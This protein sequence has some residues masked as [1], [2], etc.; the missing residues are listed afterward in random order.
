MKIGILGSG[1]VG[2]TLGSKLLEQGHEVRLGARNPGK[3][4]EWLENSGNR[5]SAGSLAEAAAFGE[6]LFNCTTGRGSLEALAAAGAG[7]LGS[8]VLVDV[9]NP[10]DFSKGMLPTLSVCNDDS[11]GEQIQRAYPKLRVVK[12]LNTINAMLMINPRQLADGN[13]DLP[14][15]GNDEQAKQQVTRLLQDDFGWKTV[16]DLGDITGS[17]ATEM[18][19]I[20]WFRL[21]DRFETPIINTKIV[22]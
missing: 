11:L 7:N 19:L 22:K 21:R 17:R 6:L 12:A 4:A 8:K 16:I 18:Y 2:Q 20:F 9:A 5:A 10:L 15:C 14:I 13:H 3:L 1:R